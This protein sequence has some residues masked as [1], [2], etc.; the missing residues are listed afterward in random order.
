MSPSD[1][2]HCYWG[3]T[4]RLWSIRQ[5][6]IVID[7]R[8][9]LTLRDCRFHA[10]ESARIR[11]NKTG[12]RDVHAW[13]AGRIFSEGPRPP[14]AVRVGYRPAEPEFRRRDTDQIVTHAVVVAF[15]PDGSCWATLS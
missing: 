5:G 12:N 3:R 4:R 13:V 10:G 2:V 15:E 8:P 1:Q 9:S 7:W 6:G 14:S 11:V